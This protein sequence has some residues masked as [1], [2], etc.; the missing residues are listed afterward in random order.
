M[1]GS[2]I[3]WS[4]LLLLFN[5]YLNDVF[6]PR[7]YIGLQIENGPVV[8]LHVYNVIRMYTYEKPGFSK[9]IQLDVCVR[10]NANAT[11]GKRKKKHKNLYT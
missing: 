11:N 8:I 5:A 2:Y 3:V 1:S 6:E 10:L 7:T 4:L 9:S